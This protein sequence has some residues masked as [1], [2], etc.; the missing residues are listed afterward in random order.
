VHGRDGRRDSRTHPY[1]SG[2]RMWDWT[3]N[4]KILR[5]M[6]K[7]I[8]P[9]ALCWATGRAPEGPADGGKRRSA[10]NSLSPS[11]GSGGTRRHADGS[12]AM[13]PPACPPFRPTAAP[14]QADGSGTAE[15]AVKSAHLSR[16]RA[17]GGVRCSRRECSRRAPLGNTTTP[18][19]AQDFAVWHCR[20]DAKTL[21]H[22]RGLL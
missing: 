16:I 17:R 8:S 12:L 21:R 6:G 15:S 18:H 14:T 11:R 19:C 1:V 20:R 3:R 22:S 9:L 5:I 7:H 2:L 10:V 13:S 4:G